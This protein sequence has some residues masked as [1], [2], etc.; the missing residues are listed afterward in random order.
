MNKGLMF[1]TA[2]LMLG[3]DK[4][5]KY[6]GPWKAPHCQQQEF[7]KLSQQKHWRFVAI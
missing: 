5:Y 3:V 2:Y 1:E 7:D 4:T 6:N